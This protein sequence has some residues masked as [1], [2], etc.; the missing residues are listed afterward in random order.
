[1]QCNTQIYAFEPIPANYSVLVRNLFN[2]SSAS[3]EAGACPKPVALRVALGADQGQENFHFF[4]DNPGEST[5]WAGN[6]K[7]SAALSTLETPKTA[8][9]LTANCEN[10]SQC[11]GLR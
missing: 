4:E 9:E 5:R 10:L 3:V 2:T 1:M 6:S 8:A 7:L 11:L